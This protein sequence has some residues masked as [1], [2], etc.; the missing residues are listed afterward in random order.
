MSVDA[1]RACFRERKM[2]LRI[3]QASDYQGDDW[4]KW[5]IWL[6]GDDAEL[7]AIE[8]VIYTLH[9]TFAKPVQAIKSRRTGF[10]LASS[11]W[12]EFE[13]YLQIVYKSGKTRKRKHWLKLVY[14]KGVNGKGLQPARARAKG[15]VVYISSGATDSAVGRSLRDLLTSRGLS[16]VSAD[17]SDAA[18][19]TDKALDVLLGSAEAAVFLLSGRPTLWTAQEIK[20]ALSQ[21]VPHI[22]PLTVGSKVD[23]PPGLEHLEALHVESEQD[24]PGLVDQMLPDRWG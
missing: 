7:S 20:H 21:H 3:K 14:P 4:W 12:G 23:L 22:I 16:V 10:K 18:L 15:P 17:D 24:L 2:T 6:D 9:P 8:R 19:P 1:N 11:G 5:S 13:I